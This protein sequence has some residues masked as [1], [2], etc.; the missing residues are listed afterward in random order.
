MHVFDTIN[1][2]LFYGVIL[3]YFAYVSLPL[4]HKAQPKKR[5][6]TGEMKYT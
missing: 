5:Y 1:N 6:P 4:P 3:R 2:L